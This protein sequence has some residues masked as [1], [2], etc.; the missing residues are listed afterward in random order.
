MSLFTQICIHGLRKEEL[1]ALDK[2]RNFKYK[3]ILFW[4]IPHAILVRNAIVYDN[5]NKQEIV[6]LTKTNTFR[7][8]DLDLKCSIFLYFY[9]KKIDSKLF[10][11]ASNTIATKFHKIIKKENLTKTQQIRFYDLRHIHASYL[12]ANS[13]NQAYMLKIIQERLRTFFN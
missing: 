2:N 4:N 7:C 1:L 6:K 10:H 13:K 9:F 8:V 11:F 12:I 5:I 3:K